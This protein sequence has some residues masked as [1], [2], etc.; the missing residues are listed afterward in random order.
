MRALTIVSTV[1]ALLCGAAL[2]LPQS[3]TFVPV[4]SEMLANPSPNDWLM[5]NRTYDSQRYSPLKQIDKGNVDQLRMVWTRGQGAGAQV[6]IPLVHNGVMYLMAPGAAV[7][8][9]DATN[10][11]LLWEYQRKLPAN[12]AGQARSKTIG[13]WEDMI[14][15]TTPDSFV[16]A[17]DAKTG[18]MRWESKTDTRGN[19]SGA[20]VAGDKIISG[21]SCTRNHLNCYILAHDAETGKLLWK[22][23]TAA[24]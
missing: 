12:Q 17:L 1:I 4:T 2:L 21:G 15:T 11:N 23:A 20:V 9:L 19:I 5:Y 24:N 14:Y 10:G 18:E 16:V 13:M 7:Q 8:A 3:R 22:F 6:G